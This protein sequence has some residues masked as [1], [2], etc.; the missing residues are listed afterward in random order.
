MSSFKV[1]PRFRHVLT[2]TPDEFEESIRS[3]LKKEDSDYVGVVIPGYIVLKTNPEERHFW[4]PQ[5]SLSFDEHEEGGTLVRGLYGPN[6]T[7]WAIFFFGY[8]A[9]GLGS[10]FI[11]IMGL[12]NVALGQPAPVLWILP[13]LAIAA[14]GLYLFAQ[15]GQ[16]LGA[17]QMYHLHSYY[18]NLTHQKISIS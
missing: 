4:S 3:D 16:K 10:L 14:A 17:D 9:L 11:A 18:E 15:F 8:V 12:S 6:P 2:V 7:V 5:L 13:G 1:R